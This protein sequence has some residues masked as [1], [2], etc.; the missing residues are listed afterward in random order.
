MAEGFKAQ[1]IALKHNRKLYCTV[2]GFT[3]GSFTAQQKASLHR[4]QL[5]CTTDSFIV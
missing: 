3:A 5:H 1:Q 4:R 2:E